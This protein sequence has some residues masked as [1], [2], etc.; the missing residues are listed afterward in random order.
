MIISGESVGDKESLF[1]GIVVYYVYQLAL[2]TLRVST[3][4]HT[5]FQVNGYIQLIFLMISNWSIVNCVSRGIFL[6]LAMRYFVV[7]CFYPQNI[8]NIF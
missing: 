8:K 4:I 6:A 1:V 5:H 3:T 7:F 2:N